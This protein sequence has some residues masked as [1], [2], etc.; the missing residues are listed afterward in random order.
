MN[1]ATSLPVTLLGK[2]P[3]LRE[4]AKPVEQGRNVKELTDA[5]RISMRAHDGI[6]IAAPQVGEGLRIFLID[7][8]LFPEEVRKHVPGDVFI[9]PKLKTKGFKREKMEEGCL[10]IP[11]VFGEVSRAHKVQ[12]RAFDADWNAIQLTADGLLARVFQHEVDHLN[13]MLFVDRAEKKSLHKLTEEETLRPWSVDEVE[14][15]A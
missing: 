5:M 2:A 9:N 6:G 15:K 8:D 10:S 4:S 12:I 11:S 13:G 14:P 1:D 3:I 7:L